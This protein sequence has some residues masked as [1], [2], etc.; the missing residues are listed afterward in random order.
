[1]KDPDKV[2]PPSSNLVLIALRVEDSGSH[3]P[4]AQLDDL[5]LDLC[6][7]SASGTL[8]SGL[9]GVSVSLTQ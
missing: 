4:L 6:D 7:H 3:V 9:R 2:I 8:I 5:P 1:M